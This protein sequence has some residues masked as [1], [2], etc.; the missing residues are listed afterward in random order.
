LLSLDASH[1]KALLMAGELHQQLANYEPAARYYKRAL[2]IDP[3]HPVAL[4]GLANCS[5][6]QKDH[7]E[8]SLWWAKALEKDPDNQRL[9]TRA[10]DALFN[11]GNIEEAEQHF[12]R[13]LQV[14][15]DPYALLGLARIHRS[16]NQIEDAQ[17]CCQQVL[18]RIPDHPRALEELAK[19]RDTPGSER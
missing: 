3:E 2:D 11:T 16:R 4:Y 7:A 12:Q 18:D 10:G 19:I 1:L 5:R 6:G 13:S 14:G 15:F 9:N 8:G 17:T